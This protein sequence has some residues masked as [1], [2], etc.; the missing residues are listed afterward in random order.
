MTEH[1]THL[2]NLKNRFRLAVLWGVRYK[3]GAKFSNFKELHPIGR[4]VDCSGF[5]RWLVYHGSDGKLSL[6]DGSVNQHSQ[7]QQLGF[8]VR[9]YSEALYSRTG[10]IYICFFRPTQYL[11]GHV[12]L[13]SDGMTM[14]SH[15]GK[16]ISTR[17]GRI[18]ALMGRKVYC[19]RLS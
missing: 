5:M 16:G 9:E 15:Y 19:Y 7:I 10:A 11:A 2:Y 17:S 12:W 3:F 18:L 14:E 4:Y 8:P 6:V 13:L 1:L